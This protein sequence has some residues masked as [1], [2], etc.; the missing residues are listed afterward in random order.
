MGIRSIHGGH[1]QG[2]VHIH[3]I[4][5]WHQPWA[6]QQR[7]ARHQ[8]TS[9]HSSVHSGGHMGIHSIHGG[10]S[11]DV[12]IHSDHR[13]SQHQQMLQPRQQR[14][15]TCTRQQRQWISSFCCFQAR[16]FS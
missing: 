14:R 1:T 15:R 6:Q 12:H 5:R 7:L 13:D 4:H 16:G 2:D 8:R 3:S 9:C 11:Q 10:H